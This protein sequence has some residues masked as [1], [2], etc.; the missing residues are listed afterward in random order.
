MHCPDINAFYPYTEG[1]NIG[2]ISMSVLQM[3]YLRHRKINEFVKGHRDIKWRHK[4][5]NPELTPE[6]GLLAITLP[7]DLRFCFKLYAR[8][9]W[10]TREPNSLFANT[11]CNDRQISH[12]VECVLVEERKI[13]L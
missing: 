1:S 13:R 7:T 10:C 4:N 6:L 12:S 5:W 3:R 8:H 11:S 9:C 2:S